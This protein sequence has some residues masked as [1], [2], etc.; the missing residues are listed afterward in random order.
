M[1]EFGAVI[2]R[3]IKGIVK[4]DDGLRRR[5]RER[6]KLQLL[7]AIERVV[8]TVHQI[9][10]LLLNLR[11]LLQ[12][13]DRTVHQFADLFRLTAFQRGHGLLIAEP[14]AVAATK[15]ILHT[16]PGE[17]LDTAFPRMRTLSEALFESEEAAEG[18]RAFFEKRS[19]SWVRGNR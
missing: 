12:A 8:V 19:P 7:E 13:L 2:I 15:A 5:H 14:N 4:T 18:M 10:A 1:A 6:G 3:E 11:N 16:V 9:E 17:P